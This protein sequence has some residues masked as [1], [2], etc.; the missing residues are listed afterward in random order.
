MTGEQHAGVL[1]VV[2]TPIGNREDL[3]RRAERILGEVDCIFCEDTR[4][5]GKLL[6]DLGISTPRISLHEHNE[7]ARIENVRERLR[8]GESCALISDAGTPLINDPGFAL[9]HALRDAGFRI[10]PVPG[11]SA[12]IA[13]LSAAGLPTD[14]FSYEGFLPAKGGARRERLTALANDPRT[15]VFYEAPHRLREMLVDAAAALGA[16]RRACV[17]REITK[18]HEE[19]RNGSL[20]ELVAWTESDPNATRGE[21]VVM[22]A[23]AANEKAS[24]ALNSDELLRALLEELPA[25]KAAKIAA[26]LTGERR[27]ALYQRALELSGEARE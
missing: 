8:R 27:Q 25:S 23:G 11:A 26:S 20:A 15:L 9:V 19:F 6:A 21:I 2:A 16:Q 1:Y 13:A 14:R 7:S 24:H 18:L 22:I 17:A 3:T 5:S 4:H 10:V 12:V